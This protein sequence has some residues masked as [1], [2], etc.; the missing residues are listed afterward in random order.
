[1]LLFHPLCHLDFVTE[2]KIQASGQPVHWAI[3]FAFWA[4]SWMKI[5]GVSPSWTEFALELSFFILIVSDQ[6]AFTGGM[7][8]R[9][10]GPQRAIDWKENKQET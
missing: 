7:L 6:A 9:I 10:I 3:T 4:A 5:L 2:D 1:M 8:Q